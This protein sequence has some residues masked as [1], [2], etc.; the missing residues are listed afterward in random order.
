MALLS[1]VDFNIIS[2]IDIADIN[3]LSI[4]VDVANGYL[5]TFCFD[6]SLEGFESS[7]KVIATAIVENLYIISR[8]SNILSTNSPFISERFG[9]YSYK[10][11]NKSNLEDNFFTNFSSIIK[12]L[13]LR[14]LL[15]PIPQTI[16]T[17]VFKELPPSSEGVRDWHKYNDE[18]FEK[19][20]S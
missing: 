13:F 1:S 16:T 6:E 19:V 11:F 7:Y 5:S 20:I 4:W 15:Q 3:L 9:S 18:E 2:D 12:A 8:R 10:R 14:Y 17:S